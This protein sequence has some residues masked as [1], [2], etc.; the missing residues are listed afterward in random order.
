[1]VDI[2]SQISVPAQ[3]IAIPPRPAAPMRAPV[4]SDK[5]IAATTPTRISVKDVNA[6]YGQKQALF[7]VD[8]E[9][10]DNAVTAFIGGLSAAASPPCCAA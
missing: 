3:E 4:V 10:P 1:V 7:D 6:F 5:S 8:I 2:V 9:I